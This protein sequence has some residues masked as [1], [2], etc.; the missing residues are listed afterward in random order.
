MMKRVQS[1]PSLILLATGGSPSL[2]RKLSRNNLQSLLKF[3]QELDQKTPGETTTFLDDFKNAPISLKR[4]RFA[5]F[6]DEIDVKSSYSSSQSANAA[7]GYGAKTKE[8]R[9]AA[10]SSFFKRTRDSSHSEAT[11]SEQPTVSTYTLISTTSVSASESAGIG[12]VFS[13][14]GYCAANPASTRAERRRR[15]SQ[16]YESKKD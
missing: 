6:G 5:S 13:Y 16:F 14:G 7:S 15:I 1:A 12:E 4:G 2:K 11:R 3:K 10:V 8:E 9:R